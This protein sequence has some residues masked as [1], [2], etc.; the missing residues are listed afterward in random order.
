MKRSSRRA[1]AVPERGRVRLRFQRG[2][3]RVVVDSSGL[4]RPGRLGVGRGLWSLE[5]AVF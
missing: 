1:E 2:R 4:W 3:K 5:S